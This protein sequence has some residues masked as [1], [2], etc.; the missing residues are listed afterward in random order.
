MWKQN[1]HLYFHCM[2]SLMV[3]TSCHEKMHSLISV[4]CDE[5]LDA[6][7]WMD[8]PEHFASI[9]PQKYFLKSSF[10]PPIRFHPK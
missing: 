6:L 7:W 10:L 4:L 8:T 2:L 5:T 1:F 9:F 3:M